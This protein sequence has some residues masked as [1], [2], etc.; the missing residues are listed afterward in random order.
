MET[1]NAGVWENEIY[2]KGQHLNRYPYD[3]IVSFIY[4]NYPRDKARSDIKILEIGCGAGNNCWFAAREG[5]DVTGIDGSSSAINFAKERFAAEGLAGNFIVGDFTQ[6]PF[7]DNQFDIVFDRGSIVCCNLEG[8]KKAISE[9][10]RVLKTGGLFFFNPY[11][12]QHTSFASGVLQQD[13]YVSEIKAGSLT[14]LGSLCFYSHSDVLESLAGGWR[15]KK[16]T[17]KESRDVS[18]ADQHIH[19]EWE[20]IASK[21]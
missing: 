14:G 5:F 18:G 10:N 15:I 12:Q 19:A 4:R 20:V 9:A 8:G 1:F 21:V 11:S 16:I 17:H 2:G 3:N 7:E 13:G 6:L